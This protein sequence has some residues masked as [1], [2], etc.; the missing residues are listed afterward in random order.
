MTWKVLETAKIDT[1]FSDSLQMMVNKIEEIYPSAVSHYRLS[2]KKEYFKIPVICLSCPMFPL[3]FL[4]VFV[5]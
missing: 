4:F 3:S 2:D 5:I 1:V